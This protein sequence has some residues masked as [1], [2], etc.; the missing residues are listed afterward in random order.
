MARQFIATLRTNP[1]RC[2]HAGR[3]PPVAAR[4]P[5]HAADLPQIP[6]RAP[7]AVRRAVAVAL[8]TVADAHAATE[9]VP[10][11]VP[12]NAL[13]GG[14]YVPTANGLRFERA[15]VVTDAVASGTQTV[16]ARVTITRLRLGGPAVA[17]GRLTLRSTETTT[18]ITGTVGGRRVALRV[19]AP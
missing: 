17:H 1:H 14:T 6:V 11:P 18:R 16:G 4:P 10:V 15:R 8:A 5:L 13:R 2:Q 12:V 7:A 19:S 9:I 3:P